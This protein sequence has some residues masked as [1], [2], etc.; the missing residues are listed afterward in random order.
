M[1]AK[2]ALSPEIEGVH[3]IQAAMGDR[4]RCPLRVTI[5]CV[6]LLSEAGMVKAAIADELGISDGRVEQVLAE[7]RHRSVLRSEA[8]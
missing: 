2:R 5:K 3:E 8:A 1:R 6:D 4:R 7:S